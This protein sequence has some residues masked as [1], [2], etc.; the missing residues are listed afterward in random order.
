MLP[1]IVARI[2]LI[3]TLVLSSCSNPSPPP[4]TTER[5]E[6]QGY[7]FQTVRVPLKE[8]SLQLYWK[9]PAGERYGTFQSLERELAKGNQ[10]LLFA[11]NAGIFDPTYTPCGLHVERGAEKV[12]LNL[13]EGE[14]N[15]HLLPNGVFLLTSEGGEI[16]ES[17]EYAKTVGSRKSAVSLAV[18]SGPLLLRAGNIHDKFNRD[19]EN[20]KIRSGVGIR[21]R[22]E[23]IFVLSNE[24]VTFHAFASL[25]RDKLNC[26]DALYLDGQISQFYPSPAGSDQESRQFAGMFAIT[27]RTQ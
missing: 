21:T 17:N 2:T 14:G 3:L 25:F 6:H 11:T 16:L 18:Q 10:K 23:I 12:P 5:V 8:L 22:E 27:A 26:T 24:P 4:I 1:R 13:N 19:S 7:S 20:R 9:N 15:F